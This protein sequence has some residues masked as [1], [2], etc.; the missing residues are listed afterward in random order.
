MKRERLYVIWLG[1]KQRCHSKGNKSTVTRWY[2]DKGISVCDE[3]RNN[4]ANFKEWALSHGYQ[5]DLTIDRINPFGNYE[6]ENCRWITR[7]ENS[8]NKAKTYWKRRKQE[9]WETIETAIPYMSEYDKGYFLGY[10]QGLLSAQ[11]QRRKEAEQNDLCDDAGPENTAE[12]EEN[13]GA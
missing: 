12:S 3:W 1:M 4:F 6:P 8:K 7:S 11:E 5:D 13:P 9:I 10:A 2:R